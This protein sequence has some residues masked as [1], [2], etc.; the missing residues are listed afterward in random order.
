MRWV[1]SHH[2]AYGAFV[3]VTDMP[4]CSPDPNLP[5]ENPFP[6]WLYGSDLDYLANV[7]SAKALDRAAYR[8]QIALGLA[9]GGRSR[10]VHRLPES[11]QETRLRS[12]AAGT[13]EA[14]GEV[15]SLPQLPWLDRLRAFLANVPQS[16]RVLLVMPPVY[17]ASLPQPGTKQATVI[18]TCKQALR[19]VV[20]GRPHGGFLDFRIDLGR[21]HD[22]ADFVDVVHYRHGL[23]SEVEDGMIAT[24]RSYD[25]G[26][27]QAGNAATVTTV[28]LRLNGRT[29]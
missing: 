28:E 15:Q 21:T 20:A 19:Q 17:F 18:D 10:R 27:D 5:L 8:I 23:A 24:L 2:P 3:I 16:V 29:P 4:W 26:T 12:S 14:L 25:V 22:A 13:P 7:L 6:F 9:A 1:I 11:R